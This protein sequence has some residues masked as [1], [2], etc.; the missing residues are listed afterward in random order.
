MIVIKITLS[1]KPLEKRLNKK[2]KYIPKKNHKN[3][4]N[5]LSKNY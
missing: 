2:Q 3:I 4:M 5:H 1:P